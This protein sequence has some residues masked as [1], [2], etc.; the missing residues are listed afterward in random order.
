ME[1]CVFLHDNSSANFISTHAD[2]EIF[3][4]GDPTLTTSFSSVVDEG[5]GGPNTTRKW[6]S[7][8]GKQN[9]I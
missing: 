4:R 6:P 5:K 2:P 9:T 1:N 8:A 3:Q 7:S